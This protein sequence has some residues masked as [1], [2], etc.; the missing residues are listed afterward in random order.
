MPAPVFYQ[1]LQNIF[2]TEAQKAEQTIVLHGEVIGSQLQLYVP[3]VE[4]RDYVMVHDNEILVDNLR[5]VID[6]V[7]IQVE[8]P[9]F[10]E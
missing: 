3:A 4:P 6:L 1:A 9:R 5:L 2:S 7:D 10:S 8:G